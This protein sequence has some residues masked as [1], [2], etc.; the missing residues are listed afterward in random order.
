MTPTQYITIEEFS[1]LHGIEVRLIREFI[2]FGLIHSHQL[3]DRD[4]LIA[5]DIEQAERLVR[6]YQDLGINKEGIEIILSMRQQI[7]EL[8]KELRKLRHKT[9]RLEQ[10]SH[11]F[12][13]EIP[14]RSG[15]IIDHSDFNE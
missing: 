3:Q 11:L 9:S 8:N 4:C 14:N 2:D 6:L 10:E 1:N 5:E 13:I 7:I 12:L 15:L